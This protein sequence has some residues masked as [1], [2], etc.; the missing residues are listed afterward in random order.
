MCNI[1]IKVENLGKRYRIGQYVGGRYQYATLRDVISDA[2]AFSFRRLRSVFSGPRP[3]TPSPRPSTHKYIWALRE[4]SFEVKRSEVVGII[5]KNG[6]GKTTLLKILTGITE[7]TEGRAELYGRVGSLLEVGTGFHPELT[8]RENIYL[9]GAILG[10][11]RAEI[12]QRFDEIVDFSG[13][14]KYIDTPVKRYSSG[15]G[16]RLGFAVAVHLKP[17]ILLVDEVLAVGD[18]EFQQKCLGKMEDVAHSG[19]TVLFVSHNMQSIRE[20]TSRAL[21]LEDGKLTFDGNTDECIAKYIRVAFSDVASYKEFP[22]RE[23]SEIQPI[24]VKKISLMDG[25]GR[26]KSAFSM[27]GPWCTEIELEAHKENVDFQASLNIQNEKG[28]YVYHFVSWD[29]GIRKFTTGKH[30]TVKVSLPKLLLYPGKFSIDVFI[31][32]PGRSSREIDKISHAISF[33]VDQRAG[34]E[35]PREVGKGMAVVHEVPKWEITRR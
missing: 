9:S 27:G 24:C 29:T 17:E 7:L 32:F 5:G 19:K 33:T 15:M 4:V 12:I 25:K 26:Y 30:S 8:G 16:V 21:L 35:V 10:M 3:S 28:V 6:A 22:G 31:G 13:V 11:K 1:A 2:A 20:L 34:L 23:P 14:E 18:F